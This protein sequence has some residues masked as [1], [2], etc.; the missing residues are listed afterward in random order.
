MK[1]NGNIK[2]K[3]ISPKIFI[4]IDPGKN[5]GVAII[6]EVPNFEGTI[7]FRCPKTPIDM[8]YTLISAIPSDIPYKDV[9]VTIEHVHAMPKNGVVSMFSF[10]QNLGQWEGILGAFELNVSYAGP[11]SWMSHYDCKPNMD[12]KD[13][14]RYLRGLAE[15]L[16]PNI[17]MTFNISDALLIA[18]YN[19][20]IYYKELASMQGR[21]RINSPA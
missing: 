10:G 7:C 19:K 9:L 2:K 20:E 15:E 4:G 21:N 3:K 1:Y 5:G 11:R 17:K 6:N 8:A 16:F 18:N 13:R 14:K 12:K